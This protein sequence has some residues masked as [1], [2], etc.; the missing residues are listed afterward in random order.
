MLDVA[1]VDG[2]VDTCEVANN[3]HLCIATIQYDYYNEFMMTGLSTSLKIMTQRFGTR[4]GYQIVEIN[5][6]YAMANCRLI[7]N[8]H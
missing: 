6:L 1:I 3:A 5:L 2:T 8:Y 7:D 4:T